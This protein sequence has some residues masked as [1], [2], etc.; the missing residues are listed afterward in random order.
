MSCP[1]ETVLRLLGTDVLGDRTFAEIEEHVEGCER[2]RG[3][4]EILA[5]GI[6]EGPGDDW[7]DAS[8]LPLIPGFQIDR[9]LGRGSAG[10][11]YL[12]HEPALDRLVALK[13]APGGSVGGVKGRARWIAEA[14]AAA[15]VRHPNIVR[16]YRVEET[17]EWLALVFEYIP[18]GTL[19]DRLD[20]PVDPATAARIVE[21]IASAAAGIHERGLLHL[22]IKSSNVLLDGDPDAPLDR[23]VP[24]LSDFG[25]ARV[26]SAPSD[27]EVG[28]ARLR[29]TP[30][31]MAPEQAIHGPTAVGPAADVFSIGVLL[32]ELLT[33]EPPFRAES[34]IATLDRIRHDAPVP[35]RRL[36]SSIPKELERICLTCLEKDPRSRYPDAGRLVLDL[37]AWAEGG[38]ISAAKTHRPPPRRRQSL[39][40]AAL[41]LIVLLASSAS[42]RP[43]RFDPDFSD[44]R[45]WI[46]RMLEDPKTLQGEPLRAFLRETLDRGNAFRADSTIPATRIASLGILERSLATKFRQ[47][48][49]YAEQARTLQAESVRMLDHAHAAAPDDQEIRF[50]LAISL[51]DSF[52]GDRWIDE[53]IACFARAS[54]VAGAIAIAE[55]RMQI[56]VQASDFLRLRAGIFRYRGSPARAHSILQSDLANFERMS[57]EDLERPAI[58]FRRRLTQGMILGRRPDAADLRELAALPD[59]RFLSP[60]EREELIEIQLYEYAR[61]VVFDPIDTGEGASL[62]VRL[63]EDCRSAGVDPVI[64]PRALLG[65]LTNA[66]TALAATCRAQREV[67]LAERLE[68]RFLELAEGTL[69]EYP[70]DAESWMILSEAH[71]QSAK[72]HWNES[73]DD[74]A[75]AAL[76]KAR[77]AARRASSLAPHSNPARA[78]VEDREQR[79]ARALG[80]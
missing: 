18:G 19:R 46:R 57:A 10:V 51:L 49:G 26:E 58:E 59:D 5:S 80:G 64:I 67:E 61:S 44:P 30:A 11:V 16:L 17:S 62:L 69:R 24:K 36:V 76:M 74:A 32:Y 20:G 60:A 39:I 22:D 23:L 71:V 12:A 2:C 27:T 34:V 52:N 29:G 15:R 31:S 53:S 35:P 7:P 37:R 40:G 70:E 41:L 45:A 54:A 14:R 9:E 56:Y 75:T 8:D 21:A 1:S 68:R 33:G 28:S 73:R 78:M 6:V 77:D 3:R 55:R 43:P 48:P 65:R 66:I 72:N 42:I 63:R 47:L 38:P 13:V 4:L 25:I 50:E 79:I